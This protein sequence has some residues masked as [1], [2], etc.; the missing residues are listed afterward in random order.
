MM[1]FY[2]SLLLSLH[3]IYTCAQQEAEQVMDNMLNLR[4]ALSFCGQG[5]LFTTYSSFFFPQNEFF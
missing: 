4:L 5:A 2:I 1:F 3:R